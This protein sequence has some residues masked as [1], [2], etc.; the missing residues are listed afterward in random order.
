M[1]SFIGTCDDTINYG[2]SETGP[3]L[4]Y[5]VSLTTHLSHEIETLN[6]LET[7]SIDRLL[8]CD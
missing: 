1:S 3:G 8:R 7:L 6:E 5:I 2:L 4:Q